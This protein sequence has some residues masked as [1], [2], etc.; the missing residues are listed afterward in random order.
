MEL[1]GKSVTCAILGK[2]GPQRSRILGTLFKD[3]RI[4]SLETMAG[5]EAHAKVLNR[6]YMEQIIKKTELSAFEASLM[7]H[8]KV[9][10]GKQTP[11][12][13]A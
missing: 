8:Q 10:L 6:M 12:S 5:F 9:V 13:R 2:A 4:N 11:S 1:L 3:E 7:P